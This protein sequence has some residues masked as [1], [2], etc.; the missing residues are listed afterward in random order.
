MILKVLLSN[1][2]QNH[3]ENLVEN[4]NRILGYVKF[5]ILK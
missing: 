5:L 3:S 2:Y 1:E 4:R